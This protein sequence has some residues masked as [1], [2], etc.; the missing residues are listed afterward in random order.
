MMKCA[1][2]YVS[3]LQRMYVALPKRVEFTLL[4]KDNRS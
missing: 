3:F 2:I 1:E 4:N